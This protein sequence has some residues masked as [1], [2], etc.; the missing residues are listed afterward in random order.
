[1]IKATLKT[2]NRTIAL[3]GLTRENLEQLQAGQPIRFDGNAIGVTGRT[4]AIMYGDTG[5]DIA[6]ELAATGAVDLLVNIPA[7]TTPALRPGG[8]RP[9]SIDVRAIVLDIVDGNPTAKREYAHDPAMR[10]GI[11]VVVGTLSR[12]AATLLATN[13][14]TR[15]EV[16]DIIRD[17]AVDM[18]FA[19]EP[20][21]PL[22][23][24][25]QE[26]LTTIAESNTLMFTDAPD[27]NI[28]LVLGVMDPTFNDPKDPTGISAAGFSALT[29]ALAAAGYE[30]VDG[31]ELLS[32]TPAE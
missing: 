1:M 26:D 14:H 7:D 12:T 28:G 11:E 18:S 27:G 15:P 5:E 32:A 22:A 17:I 10:M 3:M 30:I 2:G 4:I 16:E 6:A 8:H 9:E 13:R 23:T 31:P 25:G 21:H 20:G 19:H 29:S 24:T